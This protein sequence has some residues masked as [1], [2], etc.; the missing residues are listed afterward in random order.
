MTRFDAPRD[1]QLRLGSWIV[2]LVLAGVAAGVLVLGLALSGRDLELLWPFLIAPA[3]IGAVLAAAWLLA[4]R[5]FAL[6]G[7]DLLVLRPV[8]PVRIPLARIRAVGPVPS[9][10]VAGALR[11]GGNG[12]LFGRYGRCWSRGL[13]PFRLYATRTSGLVMVETEREAF[14]LSPGEPEAFVEAVRARAP[15]AG[16]WAGAGRVGSRPSLGP[17]LLRSVGLGAA[18]V[19][20]LVGVILAF[21]WGFSPVRAEVTAEAVWVE[22]RWASA[23]ELPLG[24]VRSAEVMASQYGRR[25]WRT[26]GTAIG[27]VRYGRFASRELGPFRLYA[28][29]Y[30]PYV[31]VETGRGRVVL[32]PDEPEQFVS[33]VRERLG[34]R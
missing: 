28:W 21:V 34:A 1:R 16:P 13:G 25:W 6:R 9:A 3:A 19:L 33:A 5:G 11:V 30:G 22:R 2:G 26:S 23:V 24:E 12:G 29:R 17:V 32:T 10:A 8:G 31:L 7:P 27:Q 15:A 20:A 18:A 14:V 4:P